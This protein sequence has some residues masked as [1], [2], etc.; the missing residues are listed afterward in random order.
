M[1]ARISWRT[2]AL[3]PGSSRKGLGALAGDW[4]ATSLQCIET[5]VKVAYYC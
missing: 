3:R 5:L 2:K 1:A 4:V